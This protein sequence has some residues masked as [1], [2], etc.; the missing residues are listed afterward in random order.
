MA[1]FIDLDGVL[2]DFDTHYYNLFGIWPLKDADDNL[3]RNVHKT[4][5]FFFNL[6]PTED[7]EDLWDYVE[8][9]NPTILT[10]VPAS[11]NDKFI[12]DKMEWVKKHIGAHVEVICCRSK[13]KSLYMKP[14][15]IIVDDWEKYKHLWVEKGGVW[16][17]HYTAE[18][19]IIEL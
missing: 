4:D 6:P 10:G 7:M 18:S 2:A 3:W 16:I 5:R 14:G 12:L 11:K 17:T 9:H 8:K 19:S 13:E 15:D 1:L